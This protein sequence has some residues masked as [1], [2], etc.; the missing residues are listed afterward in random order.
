MVSVTAAVLW[1]PIAVGASPGT[2]YTAAAV[3]TITRAVFNNI[4]NAAVILKVWVVRGGDTERDGDLM[5]GASAS[6]YTLAAGP[7]DPYTAP[8]LAG[9]VLNIGDMIW[10]QAT[11]ANVVN[12]MASG[13][14]QI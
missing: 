10:A 7:T 5:L 1:G 4:S 13:W 6:G 12:T 14:T 2:L 11:A 9:L 8:G 3:T